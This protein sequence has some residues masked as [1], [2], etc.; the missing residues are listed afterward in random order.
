MNIRQL[1]EKSR[2]FNS[3]MILC[4]IDYSKAF[5]CVNWNKMFEVLTDMGVPEHLTTLIHNLYVDGEARVK[6]EDNVSNSFKLGRGV[7]QGCKLSPRLFNL[8]G[9]YIMRKALDGW[10]GGISIGGQKIS[11]LRYADDTTAIAPTES[12]LA[13]LLRRIDVESQR[14]GLRINEA[15]TKLMIIDRS[16]SFVRTGELQHLET[17]SDFTYLGALIN[18]KGGCEDE[19]RRRIGMAKNAMIRLDKIWKDNNIHKNTK[20]RL[21]KTLMFS[22]FFYGA[23]TWTMRASERRRIDAFEMWIWRRMLRIHWTA[24]RTNHSIRQEIGENKTLADVCRQKILKYFGHIARHDET[25]MELLIVT[26]NA[27]G[28]RSRGRSPTRWTD[29]ICEITESRLQ[30]AVHIAENR[31]QWRRIVERD[32]ARTDHD[33]QH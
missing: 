12:E 11:N 10:D 17:V 20:L 32:T 25:S 4:F 27:N 21:V 18:N 9:E 8:Y 22:I 15:K 13:E 16:E 28:R 23:E 33:P 1:I 26:G 19:I 29:Q 3:P 30:E 6:V 24:R 31:E 2:E 5:D 14:L 7:R